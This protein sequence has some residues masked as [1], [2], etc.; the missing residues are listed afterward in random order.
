LNH[1]TIPPAL[2]SFVNSASQRALAFKEYKEEEKRT[3]IRI[4]HVPAQREPMLHA[5][6]ELDVKGALAGGEKRL[7]A[8]P[9]RG[10]ESVV[11]LGAGE[12]QRACV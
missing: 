1:L 7:G 10:R 3:L 5:G 4:L 11:C 8:V 6:E 12:E 2:S 9:R